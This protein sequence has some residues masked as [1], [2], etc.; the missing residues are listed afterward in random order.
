MKTPTIIVRLIGI[1]LLTNSII[2]LIQVGRMASMQ[3]AQNPMLGDMQIYAW[4]GIIVGLVATAIA[5]VLARLLTFDSEEP[6]KNPSLR[7]QLL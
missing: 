1:Y 3:Q 4:I 5:G 2:T 7:D 6:K